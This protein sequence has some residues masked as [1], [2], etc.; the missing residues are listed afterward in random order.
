MLQGILHL[1]FHRPVYKRDSVHVQRRLTFIP[2]S[3][4]IQPT[5]HFTFTL[6]PTPFAD[7]TVKM[8]SFVAV[9]ALA[10]FGAALPTTEPRG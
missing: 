5:F 10:A 8:Y 2:F 9:L 1:G 4:H 3:F 7:L 6:A